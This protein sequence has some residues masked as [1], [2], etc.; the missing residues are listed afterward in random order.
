MERLLKE[1]GLSLAV[2]TADEM[3]RSWQM[4]KETELH[5]R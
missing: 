4:A 3:E 1:Q 5:L 2:A